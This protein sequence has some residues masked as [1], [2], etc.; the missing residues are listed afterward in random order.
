MFD[1]HINLYTDSN[2]NTS[3]PFAVFGLSQEGIEHKNISIGNQDVGTIYIGRNIIIGALADG[4]TSGC[5]LDGT[6]YNGMGAAFIS[7][8]ATRIL[9]KI[10]IKKKIKSYNILELFEYEMMLSIKKIL[11]ILN[12][13]RFEQEPLIKN[14]LLSTILF[15]IV[16]EKDYMVAG[17]GDGDVVVNGGHKNLNIYSGDYMSSKIIN[18]N[19][20]NGIDPLE[21]RGK[22][23]SHS[24]GDMSGLSSIMIST[25]GFL[26]EDIVKSVAFDEF[27]IGDKRKILKK[28]F[29]DRLTE[30]RNDFLPSILEKKKNREWPQDDAT[31]IC[32]NRVE[33]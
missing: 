14:M 10:V 22:I 4:C 5:N 33:K 11:N 24:N 28:G 21:R 31:F 9:R 3:L 32:I 26:D 7:Y 17:C 8:M 20:N 15:F 29:N 12:P 27:F 25:D 1:Y 6:S 23:N 18:L 2:N 13:W 16:T 19:K 30:Y